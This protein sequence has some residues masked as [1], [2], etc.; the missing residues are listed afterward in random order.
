MNVIVVLTDTLRRDHLS[1]Y[2]TPPWGWKVHTPN[3]DR[4]AAESLIFDRFYQGSFPTGPT[5]Q[6]ML[7]GQYW[8]HT[9]GW[10]PLP[11]DVPTLQQV[12]GDA[13]YVSMCITDCHPYF[14]PGANYHR[15]FTG[16][17]WIR[18]QQAD[19][20][21]TSPKH[22]EPPCDPAKT[23]QYEK[24][25]AQHLRNTRGRTHESEWFAPRVFQ[26]AMD[27]IDENA[28][29]H[30]NFFLY[31]HSFDVHEPWDPPQ[32]YVDLYD[33][34]YEGE[35]IILPRYDR[36]GYMTDSEL[37]H[38]RALYS[39]E[40]SMVDRWFGKFVD[41]LDDAGKADDT[42][43]IFTA[44]HG[45]YLGDHGYIGKH[46]VLDPKLGWPLYEEIGHCPMFMRIPGQKSAR[47]NTLCQHVDLMP[48]L[49]DL[50]MTPHPTQMYGKS[51]LPSIDGAEAKGRGIA[52]NS[53]TLQTDAD[54]R[55]YSTITDGERTLVYAGANA[56]PELYDLNRDPR[57]GKNIIVEEYAEAKELHRRYVA[58]LE[59]IGTVEEKL[60]LRR[61][62]PK[63]T[64][65]QPSVV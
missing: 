19:K 64:D 58:E 21:R 23:R 20:Y 51:L 4:F 3:I 26:T 8:F 18:G 9:L 54:T 34:G 35:E 44:D 46:T 37:R 15:D 31:V 47:N 17:E 22:V 12:L 2:G 39:A 13:G 5:V 14:Y 60:A 7:T 11:D 41:R 25:V 63:V 36:T 43:V 52:I 55:V 48:T 56:P 49:L 40:I 16:F 32:H 29:E 59:L 57:Q 45:F 61:F 50:T 1:V 27:W 6:D 24:L 65:I 53:D 28:A 10:S 30:E 33:P 42:A 38:C 62:W